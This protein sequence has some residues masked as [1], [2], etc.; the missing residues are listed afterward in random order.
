MCF[1]CGRLCVISVS[2]GELQQGQRLSKRWLAGSVA[3]P[4]HAQGDCSSLLGTDE[5]G[6]LEFPVDLGGH[7]GGQVVRSLLVSVLGRVWLQ[8]DTRDEVPVI[9]FGVLVDGAVE[10]GLLNVL[11]LS[12]TGAWGGTLVRV[13][14]HSC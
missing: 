7:A 1:P 5:G 4:V 14:V 13:S 11:I 2:A 6:S 12:A 10:V 9:T 8:V 3:P